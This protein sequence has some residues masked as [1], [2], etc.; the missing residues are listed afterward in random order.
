[1]IDDPDDAVLGGVTAKVI[2]EPI[3][4]NNCRF[5]VLPSS[6]A[7]AG[8]QERSRQEIGKASCLLRRESWIIDVRGKKA[9]NFV[10]FRRPATSSKLIRRWITRNSAG[11]FEQFVYDEVDL[12]S[13][14]WTTWQRIGTIKI[15]VDWVRLALGLSD[16]RCLDCTQGEDKTHSCPSIC[17]ILN[18]DFCIG[19][20]FA[21]R[22]LV[23]A[24]YEQYMGL[25]RPN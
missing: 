20:L 3:T 9:A 18:T 16:W 19:Y 24:P 13:N 7:A 10:L 21:R 4:A 15:L 11:N 1:M 25:A 2:K 17:F 5:P 14:S 22:C 6:S 23:K 12:T 8:G